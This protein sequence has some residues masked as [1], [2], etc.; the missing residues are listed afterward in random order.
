MLEMR[1]EE[2]RDFRGGG[3]RRIEA[4]GVTKGRYDW[5]VGLKGVVLKVTKEIKRPRLKLF[6]VM[7]WSSAES[8]LVVFLCT[9]SCLSG[10]HEK[11]PEKI[12]RYFLSEY[13]V[14]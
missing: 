1:K 2:Y 14:T 4:K 9:F 13:E 7:R 3:G 8:F 5:G 12:H 10:S 6:P 11:M